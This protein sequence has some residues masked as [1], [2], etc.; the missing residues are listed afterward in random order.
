MLA[1]LLGLPAGLVYASLFGLVAAESA[2]LPV[3]GETA[4]IAAGVLASRHGSVSIWLVIPVAAV[5]AIIG[6]NIGFALGRRGGR[7]LL[8]REGRGAAARRGA[9]ERGERFFERHGPKA[10]FLA[11]W[12]PGLRV[13]GAWVAGALHMPWRSFL[14]WNALGGIGWATSVGLA[15]YVLGQAA[16]RIFRTFGLIGL[17][18]AAL[19]ALIGIAWHLLRR[20]AAARRRAREGSPPPAAA[21]PDPTRGSRGP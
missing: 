21:T 18:A 8:T 12:L 5:A 11:R 17:G 20:R 2:G 3:P 7:W 14:L 1:L 9:L 16:E 15:A 6:D 4:L 19:L 13:I 10:V